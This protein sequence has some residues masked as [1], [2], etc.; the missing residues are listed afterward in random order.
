M[1][2]NDEYIEN[3]NTNHEL[4]S[5]MKYLI[6]I[7][8]D[9]DLVKI[10]K[11]IEENN[12]EKDSLFR[13][14]LFFEQQVSLVISPFNSGNIQACGFVWYSREK[15]ILSHFLNLLISLHIKHTVPFTDVSELCH[16]LD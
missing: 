4:I 7:C 13:L 15:C 14:L 1:D 5:F 6:H 10:T 2:N 16:I 3:K 11:N 8:G 12:Y 9:T